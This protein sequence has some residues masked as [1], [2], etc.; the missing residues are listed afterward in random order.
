MN[1]G[2]RAFIEEHLAVPDENVGA[3]D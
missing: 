2:F 3:G 1:S